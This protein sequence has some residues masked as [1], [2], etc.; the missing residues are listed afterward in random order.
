MT[1]RIPINPSV[2]IW[3]RETSGF[4]LSDVAQSKQF[5]N[6]EKWEAGEES[7]TYSQ[8]EKLAEK[9]HR[10]IAIFFF[11]SPP[12]EEAIERSLRALSEKDLESVTPVV[13][14]LF[15]KAKAFQLSLKELFEGQYD[16][17]EQKLDWMK[18]LSDAPI[19]EITKRVREK[20]NVSIGKQESWKDSNEALQNW[21]RVLADNGVFVFKDAFKSQNV[22]GFC[23]Y[24]EL[25]PVIYVNNSYSKN[26]QIF[27]IFHEVAHLIFK[28]SYLDIF[29]ETFW[30]LE[31]TNP[32]HEEVKCNAFAAEFLVPSSDFKA[33]IEGLDISDEENIYK[34]AETY[35]VSREVILRK[36]L[37]QSLIGQNSYSQKAEEWY[38]ASD[39][40]NEGKKKGGGN[41]YN[42]KAAYLGDAYISLVFSN[43][44]RGRIDV[45][46][47][48]QYLD[49]KPKSFSGIEEG[50]L[51]QGGGR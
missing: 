36:L 27:T 51:K 48:S 32:N 10:P 15:R 12:R 9:Y 30:D 33:R 35:H 43:Y 20:I 2:L 31:D 22:S 39:A 26:R 49:I 17:Q 3:A 45:E 5:A 13:R 6:L 1:N 23:I 7:P 28:Q 38:K 21:R 42:T 16:L 46:Q 44:Y 4:A 40:H 50:F 29:N 34:L 11:P 18:A 47:A 24:D 25:F 41:Y 19:H 37:D 14:F 8:L